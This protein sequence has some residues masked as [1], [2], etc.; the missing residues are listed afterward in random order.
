MEILRDVAALSEAEIQGLVE[1]GVLGA[2]PRDTT[3]PAPGATAY[4]AGDLR[5]DP[6]Y[7]AAVQALVDAAHQPSGNLSWRGKE[8]TVLG[9]LDD[10]QVVELTNSLAGAFC[11]KLL[12]DQGAP[13]LKLNLP[14]AAMQR[15]MNR[16]FSAV[17]HTQTAVRFSRF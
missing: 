6:H 5:G 8:V 3:R 11:A 7:R 4:Q 17:S 14:G 2:Q 9:L 10:V 12:A 15:A 16:R 1:A 13:T